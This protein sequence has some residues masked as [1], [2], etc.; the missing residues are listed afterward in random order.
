MMGCPDW[1]FEDLVHGLDETCRGM[2][3]IDAVRFQ[4]VDFLQLSFGV[5][6]GG[7]PGSGRSKFRL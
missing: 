4:T 7:N 3:S 1:M 6:P 5:F 2:V